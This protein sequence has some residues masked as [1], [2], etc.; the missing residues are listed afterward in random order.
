[1]KIHRLHRT[2]SLP[3]SLKQA[4]A[5][6][7]DPANLQDITPEWLHFRIT[8]E[9]A[10]RMYPGMIITYRINVLFGLPADW[11]TEITHVRAPHYF[12]DEQRFGPYRF[13][14]HQHLFHETDAGV[15]MEDLLHYALPFGPAGRLLHRFLIQRKL[16][17]IFDF[18]K[19]GLEKRFGSVNMS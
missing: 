14:H 7:S 2:Q 15:E 5:F 3:I 12:V 6:F 9:A 13:W 16:D 18:R 17:D 10:G 1:M 4:W 11:I 8:S 19:T